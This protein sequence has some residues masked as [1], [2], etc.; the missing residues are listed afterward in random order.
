MEN[1]PVA[2][3]HSRSDRRDV[4]LAVLAYHERIGGGPGSAARIARCKM[5]TA[6]L[7]NRKPLEIPSTTGSSFDLE[8]RGILWTRVLRVT[9]MGLVISAVVFL[10]HRTWVDIVP[11]PV[12]PELAGVWRDMAYLYPASFAL[13]TLLLLVGRRW[14]CHV[15]LMIFTLLLMGFNLAIAIFHNAI[16]RPTDQAHFEIALIL[17]LPAALI[18]WR[19]GFQIALGGLALLLFGLKE[20]LLFGYPAYAVYWQEHGSVTGYVDHLVVGATTIAVLATVAVVS[21]RTLY[22]MRKQVHMVRRLG[23]YEIQREL[24]RGG[25]GTVYLARHALIRRPTA[26]KVLH[27][28]QPGAS[29]ALVRFE[30]EVQLSANLTHPNTINI[31]DFGRAGDDVFYYAMEYLEGL[32]LQELVDRFGPLP[33]ARVVYVMRQACRSLIEAHARGIVHRDI[34][35]SNVFLT[36]RGGRHDFVKVLDFGLAKQIESTERADLTQAQAFLG[37]PRYVA[38]ETIAG[39][40]R[41]DART[42]VYTLGGVMT[43]LL[44]GEPPFASSSGVSLIVDHLQQQPSRPS[45]ISETPIPL[46]LD[47]I[48]LQC[49]QKRPDDR[50]QNVSDLLAAL[51]A[52]PLDRPWN[53]AR[54]RDWWDLHGLRSERAAFSA[55]TG[56]P[57]TG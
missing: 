28:P 7:E 22:S 19:S 41:D 31:Y 18:P 53:A 55:E 20:V 37:T 48:V 39:G 25:M 5:A 12:I 30:R 47:E 29:E 13:A 3:R 35:P 36:E 34:K 32:D 52:V 11:P 26:V 43:W 46:A 51:E 57:R 21:S 23:N 49:L 45:E 38:P 44:T 33:P 8:L 4:A 16:C 42:D 56:I 40:G 9:V 6:Q 50:Y 54:A 1:A 27:A 2:F 24:G 14:L 10:V 17:F 15:K